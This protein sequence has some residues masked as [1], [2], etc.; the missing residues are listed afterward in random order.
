MAAEKHLKRAIQDL[1]I[2]GTET[3]NTTLKW[4]LLFMALN[5]DVQRGVQ[6]E[7]ERVIGSSRLPTMKDK[8]EM[9]YTHATI[10]ECQR[11]ANIA[12]FSVPRCATRA[13]KVCAR[14][15][16]RFSFCVFE[17]S[18][19]FERPQ[20]VCS[21]NQNPCA[22]DLFEMLHACRR[23]FSNVSRTQIKHDP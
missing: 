1:F 9:V 22:N 10:M 8:P 16:K 5:T 21:V 19:R 12:L 11:V 18:P 13:T 17:L 2:A 14:I 7:I 20:V 4:S 6:A 23:C 15:A 3:T